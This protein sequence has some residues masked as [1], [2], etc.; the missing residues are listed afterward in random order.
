MVASTL[1]GRPVWGAEHYDLVVGGVLAAKRSVWI[2]TA[3]LKE[4]MVAP[5]GSNSRRYHSVLAEFD[6]LAA[7]GVELRVLHAAMPSRPFRDAF[8]RYPR[9]VTGGLQLRQ[10]PRVHFKAVVVD[11]SQVYLG[12]ANWTGAGLGAKGEE[13]RNFELGISSNDDALLDL[14]QRQFEEI[15][16]GRPCARCRLRGECEAPLDL[17]PAATERTIVRIG[18]PKP[19]RA[20]ARARAGLP[21]EGE[22]P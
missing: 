4:L 10:C 2:A 17:A 21:R 20:G 19:T 11:A 22:A 5:F 14:V 9:L 7:A 6:R 15:W 8:D 3:N 12:S 16:R 1:R 18:G 13:R